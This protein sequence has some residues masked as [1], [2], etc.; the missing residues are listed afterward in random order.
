[1]MSAA[2]RIVEATLQYTLRPKKN[3]REKVIAEAL[4]FVIEEFQDYREFG[5][6]DMV[7]SCRDLWE[8]I[9]ELED[10]ETLEELTT[11]HTRKDLDL[12]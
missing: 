5:C 8:L 2:D 10:T 6:G 11:R 7:V 9:H 1:M 12:L 4:R 3:D